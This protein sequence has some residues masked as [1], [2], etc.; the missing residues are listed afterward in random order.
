MVSSD[1]PAENVGDESREEQSNKKVDYY[2]HRRLLGQKKKQDE[3]I[4]DMT[5]RLDAFEQKDLESNG[6]KDELINN[7]RNANC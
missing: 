6:Q 2:T 7:L 5:A 4:N 3:L 1:T